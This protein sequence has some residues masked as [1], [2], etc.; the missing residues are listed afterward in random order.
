[1]ARY[2]QE[3]AEPDDVNLQRRTGMSTSVSEDDKVVLPLGE[4]TLTNNLG[5]PIVVVVTKVRIWRTV[6]KYTSECITMNI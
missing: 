3:Y 1:M 2:F 5:I 4:T 6:C